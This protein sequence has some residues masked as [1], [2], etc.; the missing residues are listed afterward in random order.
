MWY[1]Q[2]KTALKQ[3]G[4]LLPA[5]IGNKV[6]KVTLY[7]SR[8]IG[9]DLGTT[10]SCVAVMEG[11]SPSV[12]TNSEGY[13]TTPSVVAF[14][15]EGSKIVGNI[16]KRQ[17]A[18]NP[19]R[20]IFSIKRYMGSDYRKKLDG[21]NYSP[22]EISAQI[23]IKLKKDAENYIGETVT[24]AVITVPAYFND[25]Q[26]Q[27]TK[28]AGRIAG[29]NVLRIINEPTAAALAY[30]LDNGQAQKIL[31]YDLGGGTFDVSIIEIGDNV[32]EVLA[33]SGDNHLGGDDFDERIVNE[34]VEQFKQSDG[35]N[36]AKDAAAMQR[37]R[38]EA[39][40]AKK[41][42]SS[43]MNANINL[44]FI[45][46]A[47]GAAHH[48]DIHLTRQQ[49][50][51]MT[52]DLVDR[53]VAPV[54][55]ALHDAGLTKS[56]INMVLLVGGSTRIPAV[57]EKVK[58]LMGMEPSRNLNPDECVALGAAVQGGKLGGQLVAG[59]AA[60]EII[61]MDVTPLSLS[62][63]T[64]GGVASRLIERNTTIPTRHSQIFTTA[65]NFQTSV[66][67]K[68]FQGER[69]FTRD[70]KLLGNF[71]LSGI[72]RAMAG[73]PQIEVTFDIDANGIVNVSAKD[74]GTGHEQ[75]ITITSSSN[76]SEEEIERA[77]WEA[78]IYE[79]QDEYRQ[80]Q[81]DARNEA[82]NLLRRTDDLL[83]AHKKDW[84]KMNR[85]QIKEQAGSLRKA[86]AKAAPEKLDEVSAARIREEKEQL[87]KMLAQF[88]EM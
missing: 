64:V 24:D 71:R 35:I 66:D 52:Y 60:S 13:R 4:S 74:L 20:T 85:K 10:N 27:A 75:S 57:Q 58:N 12:I 31:V 82:E 61:L 76:L 48:M 5:G 40:K 30:G 72:K 83:S 53:T 46:M 47:K 50:E 77:K 34:L 63:E 16:A 32:I 19:D 36:L 45:S 37:L 7:M 41:E 49:F 38:E 15:K 22:Q 78:Q 42:L 39:E 3:K 69:K 17:A 11:E 51:R 56:Q 14:T 18:V 81:L 26:R 25:A 1:T 65:G 59:S 55:N 9:I 84:D 86:L 70:N 33:T 23:L 68:V 79:K 54:E 67:I 2:I 29:L 43:A 21:K 28:D 6:R 80:E 88:G 44:P 73:T 87:E 62:I 8:V